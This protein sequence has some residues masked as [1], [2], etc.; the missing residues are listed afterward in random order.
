M[1]AGAAAGAQRARR[2]MDFG[3]ERRKQRS[4]GLRKV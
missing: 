2:K 1:P 3:V 4:R